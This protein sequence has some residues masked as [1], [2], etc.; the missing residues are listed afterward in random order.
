MIQPDQ[1]DIGDRHSH[2]P[3]VF[4]LVRGLFAD[5][6]ALFGAEL[7]LASAEIRVNAIRLVLALA[8][9]LAGGLLVGTAFIALLA[10]LIAV[11]IPSL[12]V[13]GAA[14]ITALGALIAAAVLIAA[15]VRAVRLAPLAPR[16]AIANLKSNKDIVSKKADTGAAR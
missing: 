2:R 1:P 7:T 16:R 10:A 11:L 6:Q 13:V 3:S 12:G 5:A 8:A 9:I 14:L 15:G 4:A